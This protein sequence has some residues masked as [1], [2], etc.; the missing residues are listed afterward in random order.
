[1]QVDAVV[2]KGS[3]DT[4]THTVQHTYIPPYR[5]EALAPRGAA[6]RPAVPFPLLAFVFGFVFTFFFFPFVFAVAAFPPLA[7]AVA[8]A[9]SSMLRGLF[10]LASRPS[11]CSFARPGFLP[12]AAAAVFAADNAAAAAARS[13]AARERGEGLRQVGDAARGEPAPPPPL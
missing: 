2:Q 6:G 10:E 9:A 5:A 11:V 1:M 12:A 3:R 8:A 4:G 7:I 13:S